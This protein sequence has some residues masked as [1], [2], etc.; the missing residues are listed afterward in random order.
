MIICYYIRMN[1]FSAAGLSETEARCYEALLTKS[2]WKPSKLALVVNESRT[3]CYKI[4]EKLESFGLAKKLENTTTSRFRANNPARL[5]ELAHQ[6]RL[7]QEQAEKELQLSVQDLTSKYIKIH[8]QAGIQHYQGLDEITHIFDEI[9]NATTD[10]LFVHTRSGDD[11]YG[12]KAMHNLRMRA[13]NN[14]V[15]RKALTPDTDI[16]TSDYETFDPTVLLSRTW[17]RS[18]DY[19][20][21]VEWGT[22]DDKVYIINYGKEALGVTLQSKAIAKAFRE[23]FAMLESGQHAQ[24]WYKELPRN[25]SEPGVNVPHLS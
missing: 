14:G 19:D 21:P 8:D 25:A 11:Y 15:Q 17:L 6:K 22:Y 12:F 13:V 3:N 16:A 4:L 18:E 20:A 7:E 10:V 9:A 5:I 2:D 1:T 23:L 24:P